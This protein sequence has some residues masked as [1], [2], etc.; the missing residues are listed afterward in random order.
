MKKKYK[1]IID[2]SKWRTGVNGPNATGKGSTYLLNDGGYKC[3]LGFITQQITKKGIRS[4][5][6]P[7]DCNF[8]VPC[9]N[10]YETDTYINTDL[11]QDAMNIN[12][13]HDTTLKEKEAALKKMFK[14]TPISLKF[15]GRAVSY[16]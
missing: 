3:C 15:I 8:S 7:S 16:E 13:A 1:I 11:S 6:E 12:D 4:L 9:L 10:K 2:R 5:S 14:N